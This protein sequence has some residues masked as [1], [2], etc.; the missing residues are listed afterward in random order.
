MDINAKGIIIKFLKD[1]NYDGLC[2]EFCGCGTDD[3]APCCE[4]Y[5]TCT[6]GYSVECNKCKASVIMPDNKNVDGCEYCN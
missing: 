2:S 1:H 6:P 3:F 5:G 4:D